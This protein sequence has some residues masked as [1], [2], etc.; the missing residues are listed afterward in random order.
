MRAWPR[1]PLK[2]VV[3]INR[4]VLPEN[5][6][7]DTEFRYIDISTCG[8]GRLEAE[9]QSMRFADAPSRARRLVRQ[10]DTIIST[11]RTYLRAVWPVAGPADDLVVSTGFAVLSPRGQLDPRFLG[12]V[13]Q[14]DLVIAEIVARSVGVSYPAI[15]GLEVGELQVPV[16]DLAV[17]RAIADFLDAETGHIDSLI[18]RKRE[19]LDLIAQRRTSLVT[20]LV[21]RG[22]GATPRADLPWLTAVPSS[23][24]SV[25]LGLL[26]DVFNGSTPQRDEGDGGDIPWTTSGEIDQG[27]ITVPTAYISEEA[28]RAHGL[29]I[30]PAGSIVVGLVGQGRTRGLRARLG[31]S[32]TLNQN[33]AAICPRDDRLDSSYVG[34]LL[35]L[36][37]DDLRNGGRGGNQAALNCEMIKAYRIPVA[38]R[39]EQ[40]R[41]VEEFTVEVTRDGAMAALLTKSIEDLLERRQALITAAVNGQVKVPGVAG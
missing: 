13:A 2:H 8:R 11:V 12:W 39:D 32:T 40:A 33:L 19:V 31:I 6:P 16:P 37:Y 36:A 28:R 27:V 4:R 29:R 22:R 5:T 20:A 15:N 3:D 14:S 9:P 24:P 30:A 18:G 7:P 41:L 21:A 23:W 25:P 35:G 38:P 34:L 1:V 17:Q 26:A 10:G